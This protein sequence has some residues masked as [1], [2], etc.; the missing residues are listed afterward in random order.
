VFG[1]KK[2]RWKEKKLR[3][4]ISFLCLEW[5]KKEGKKYERK[6][7]GKL[8]NISEK[9]F[10]RKNVRKIVENPPSRNPTLTPPKSLR[11]ISLSLSLSA[12]L[13]LS[14][15]RARVP[16]FCLSLPR[17]PSVAKPLLTLRQ[18]WQAF[19]WQRFVL[20]TCLSS[21]MPLSL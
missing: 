8:R 14:S 15:S 21:C 5:R 18:R 10:P 20:E 17:Q 12:H 7:H 1:P 6:S 11:S 9:N 16:A 13:C 4:L 19:R 3:K 2:I